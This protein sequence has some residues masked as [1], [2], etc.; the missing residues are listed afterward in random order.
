MWILARATLE[1]T[2]V[3][4]LSGLGTA[5]SWWRSHLTELMLQGVI[6]KSLKDFNIVFNSSSVLYTVMTNGARYR[7]S[8]R[9]RRYIQRSLIHDR[10]DLLLRT[11][12]N[13][14]AFIINRMQMQKYKITDLECRMIKNLKFCNV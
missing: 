9:K 5:G 1:L 2:I 10:E 12:F 13:F 14:L 8:L 7:T 3:A 6:Q 4:S 11:Q